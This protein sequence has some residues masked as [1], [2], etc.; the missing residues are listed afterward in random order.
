MHY[1]LL[2]VSW[3]FLV[4]FFL[5]PAAPPANDEIIRAWLKFNSWAT[6]IVGCTDTIANAIKQKLEQE[7]DNE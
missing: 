6:I 1:L 7:Q 4:L 2:V 3:T 5:D